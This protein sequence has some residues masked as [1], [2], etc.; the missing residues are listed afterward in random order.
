MAGFFPNR[1][2]SHTYNGEVVFLVVVFL[3]PAHPIL[4]QRPAPKVDPSVKPTGP[5]SIKLPPSASSDP[6]KPTT[7][8]KGIFQLTQPPTDLTSSRAP[9][10]NPPFHSNECNWEGVAIYQMD[11]VFCVSHLN[12]KQSHMPPKI[13]VCSLR[14][15]LGLFLP[16]CV[17]F[18]SHFIHHQ[19]FNIA[20]FF[21][22]LF[23]AFL[24]KKILTISRSIHVSR[25]GEVAC[26]WSKID[27]CGVKVD[28]LSRIFLCPTTINPVLFGFKTVLFLR[29]Q[30]KKRRLH[31]RLRRR[32]FPLSLRS[33]C[34]FS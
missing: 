30:I 31:S 7:R 9:I 3:C 19:C 21:E 8:T 10:K 25:W 26:R 29:K 2:P 33:L 1:H 12:T 6:I 18:Q 4:P 34:F 13:D 22:G 27:F 14:K 5:L 32:P 28:F 15:R 24:H 20:P 17:F 11:S 16:F 23:D